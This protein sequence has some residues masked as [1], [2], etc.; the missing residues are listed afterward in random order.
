MPPW[1]AAGTRVSSAS[2]TAAGS[3]SVRCPAVPSDVASR[4][5]A[6][7][8]T[9]SSDGSRPH[10]RAR[11]TALAQPPR[12]PAPAPQAAPPSPGT[13]S[14]RGGSADRSARP[15][16][17]ARPPQGPAPGSATTPRRPQGD[18][19]PATAGPACAAPA[20]NHTA[21]TITPDAGDSR[22]CRGFRL[23]GDQLA[24]RRHRRPRATSIRRRQ[25]AAATEPAGITS[26]RQ[27]SARRIE[28]QPQRI[29]MI[30]HRLQRRRQVLPAASPA[31]TRS[32]IDWLNRVERT[33]ALLQPAHD[34]RRRQHADRKPSRRPPTAPTPQAPPRRPPPPPAPPRSDAGTPSAA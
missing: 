20:S 25:S 14:R 4:D 10:R 16:S 23:G 18:G 13:T 5:R 6:D 11:T 34:R 26:S 22:R 7:P 24:Q 28:P 33:A 3:V 2:V 17:P 15:R 30:E 27:R 32:S 8:P 31:G 1:N 12:H 19:S 9:S 21:C 29:V